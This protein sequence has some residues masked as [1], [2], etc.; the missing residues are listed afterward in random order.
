MLTKIAYSARILLGHH[1]SARIL[2]EN[3]LFCWQNASRKNRLFC[4]KFC[5]QNLSKPSST[6][7]T[8][9]YTDFDTGRMGFLKEKSKGTRNNSTG[10]PTQ[11]AKNNKDRSKPSSG[12][13]TSQTSSQTGSRSTKRRQSTVYTYWGSEKCPT[14]D[15]VKTVYSGGFAKLLVVIYCLINLESPK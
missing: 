3:A 5:R 10:N 6:V 8:N 1:Y 7:R 9:L 4:W 14:L 13:P 11:K 15:D 2:L 12:S